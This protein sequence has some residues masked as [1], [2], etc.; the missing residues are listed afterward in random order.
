MPC[1][2]IHWIVGPLA[3]LSFSSLAVADGGSGTLPPEKDLASAVWIEKGQELFA[4]SCAY[5]HGMKG[6]AGRTK[7]FAERPGWPPAKI[8]AVISK[9][10]IRGANKMPSWEGLIPED[11]IWKIVAYIKSLTPAK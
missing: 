11:D 9:G 2:S 10:R 1:F 5:C 4:Q 3:M 6:D 7:S 8:Y